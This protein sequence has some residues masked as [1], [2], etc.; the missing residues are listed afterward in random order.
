MNLR[1][2][3]LSNIRIDNAM[4]VNNT[5]AS[6]LTFGGYQIDRCFLTNAYVLAKNHGATVS[7]QTST[8][9]QTISNTGVVN[10]YVITGGHSGGLCQLLWQC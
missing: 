9:G 2:Q 4:T 10:G 8:T 7:I 1:N 5:Y 6:I 3:V